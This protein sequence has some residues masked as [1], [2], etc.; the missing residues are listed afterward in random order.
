MN[1]AVSTPTLAMLPSPAPSPEL[2]DRD[3]VRDEAG[4]ST[5]TSRQ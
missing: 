5:K 1:F 4:A 2:Q 3:G